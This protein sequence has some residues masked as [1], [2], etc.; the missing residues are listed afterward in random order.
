MSLDAFVLD[1]CF[2]KMLKS[3]HWKHHLK[4]FL[5][6]LISKKVAEREKKTCPT[7]EAKVHKL[8]FFP[9]FEQH[10]NKG[11]TLVGSYSSV[12]DVET[13]KSGF[14]FIVRL[15]L[16]THCPRLISLKVLLSL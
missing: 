10:R 11:T 1:I 14:R 15:I 9:L 5:Y 16:T 8:G 2:K 7:F 4:S 12:V 13:L 6:D 3:F